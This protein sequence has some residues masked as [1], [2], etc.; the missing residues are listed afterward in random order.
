[1]IPRRSGTREQGLT[2]LELVVVVSIAAL[3]TGI[4]TPVVTMVIDEHRLEVTTD[5]LNVLAAQIERYYGDT[6]AIPSTLEALV[7]NPG[8]TGWRG[9]YLEEYYD[10]SLRFGD[11]AYG[12]PLQL[13]NSGNAITITSLGIDGALGTADD[14][15]VRANL[16]TI[17]R[18]ITRERVDIVNAAIL[19]YLGD[20]SSEV[21][22]LPF[23][24]DE[25]FGVL[26]E[27]GYLDDDPSLIVD[28]WGD[29][30]VAF[31][32]NAIWAISTAAVTSTRL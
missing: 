1:M 21:P 13:T 17:R 23:D 5:N 12:R 3:L 2:L 24:T 15:L 4:T 20:R 29:A 19:R 11:D 25:L 14:L 28:G 18:R 8:V 32:K 22:P 31:P 26:V 30:L 9:P 16:Q 7:H 10:T 27:Q 6:L